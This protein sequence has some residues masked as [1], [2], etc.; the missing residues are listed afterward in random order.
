VWEDKQQKFHAESYLIALV[1]E[2]ELVFETLEFIN[3][4]PGCLP[5]KTLLRL[6][7]L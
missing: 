4:F 1:M 5:E 6:A 7:M 2:M 3:H